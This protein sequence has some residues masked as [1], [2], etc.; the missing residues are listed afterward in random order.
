VVL[1]LLKRQKAVTTKEKDEKEWI[2]WQ[3]KAGNELANDL[4]NQN[5]YSGAL[6]LYQAMLPLGVEPSWCWP[7]LYQMGMCYEHL[8]M[9]EKA[10]E[11]YKK[12]INWSDKDESRTVALKNQSL[13]ETYNM[14]KWRIDNIGWRKD[15]DKKLEKLMDK[16]Q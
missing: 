3:K 11:S 15:T 9:Y 14:A 5:D 6:G 12:I 13:A 2:R 10:A 4:F 7:V 16:S 8:L 1:D